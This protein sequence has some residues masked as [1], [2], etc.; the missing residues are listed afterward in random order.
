MCARM[1][2]RIFCE[3]VQESLHYPPVGTAS[4]IR[5]SAVTGTIL[6]LEM[7][8]GLSK[9][10]RRCTFDQHTFGCD[11][12]GRFAAAGRELLLGIRDF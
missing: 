4:S 7:G 11:T 9:V 10:D 1:F 12:S 2:A 3:N 5:L 8:C 6:R